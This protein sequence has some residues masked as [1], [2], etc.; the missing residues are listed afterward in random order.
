MIAQ[1]NRYASI[2]IN[3]NVTTDNFQ[4]FPDGDVKGWVIRHSAE[5]LQR[6]TRL[7][8]ELLWKTY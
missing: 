2:Y 3:I 7:A 4:R 6:R 1:I 5:T 8:C